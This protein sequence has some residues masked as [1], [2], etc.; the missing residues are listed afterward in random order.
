MGKALRLLLV[1]DQVSDAALLLDQLGRFGYDVASERVDTAQGMRAAL[2]AGE[3]DLIISDFSMPRFGAL[4]A[5][6]V[7]QELGLDLPMLIVSGSIQEE[8]AVDCLQQGADD[9]VTKGRLSRL[10]PAIER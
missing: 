7:R 6:R 5:L 1:E 4:E 3:W 10:G 9:F 8:D 2:L